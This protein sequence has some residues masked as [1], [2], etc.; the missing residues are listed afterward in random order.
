MRR[1]TKEDSE[2][3][4][5]LV[6]INRCA[7]VVKGG[8]RFSFNAIVTVGDKQGRVGIGLGKA[9]EVADAIRKATEA[10]KRSMVTIPM[11]RGTIPHEVIGRFGAGRVLLKPA[12]S[13]T[14]VIAGGPVRAVLEAAGIQ[15]VL[16]KCLGST[17]PHNAVKATFNALTSLRR[18]HD[19][20]RE[21]GM[22]LEQMLGTPRKKVV[23]ALEGEG[24]SA[25]AAA[26]TAVIEAP[27]PV[28]EPAPSAEAAPVAEAAPAP[29]PETE[30][31]EKGDA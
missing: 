26:A 27:A 3:V 28:A 11:V 6:Q 12:S 10:A 21:R 2:F 4:E 7:K 20:A 14:G 1:F 17:N 8:R 23:L 15:D 5:N 29:A 19:V 9:N 18:V 24:A 22:S 30:T 25:P 16:S 31:E 13:G